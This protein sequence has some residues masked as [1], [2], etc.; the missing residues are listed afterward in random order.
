MKIVCYQSMIFI[1]IRGE[2]LFWYEQSERD[3]DKKVGINFNLA[4]NN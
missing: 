3:M 1:L 2:I 4:G